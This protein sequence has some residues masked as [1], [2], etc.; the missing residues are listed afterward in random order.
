[1]FYKFLQHIYMERT[2]RSETIL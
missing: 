1:M 2:G